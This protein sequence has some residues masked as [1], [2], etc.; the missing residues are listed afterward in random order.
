MIILSILV[1]LDYSVPQGTSG[2]LE[3]Q[4]MESNGCV[5]VNITEDMVYEGNETFTFTLGNAVN[6]TLGS[7]SEV[8]I[9]I[10]DNGE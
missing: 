4:P 5:A 6:V 10:V 9:T 8:T 1:C 2:T 3:L 7:P